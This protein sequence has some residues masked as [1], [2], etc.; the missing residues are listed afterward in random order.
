MYHNVRMKTI[1]RIPVTLP[2]DLLDKI[3]RVD[4]DRKRFIVAA[5]EH[6]LAYR[7][8]HGLRRS[9]TAPHPATLALREAALDNWA[10]HLPDEVL[11]DAWAGTPVQWLEGRGWTIDRP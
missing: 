8:R 2:A 10:A 11:V 7:R 9:I 5:I 3:D 6:E 4:A 1:K